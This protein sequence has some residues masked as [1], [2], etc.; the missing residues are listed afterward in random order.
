[1]PGHIDFLWGSRLFDPYELL[2]EPARP[3]PA[4]SSGR[5]LQPTFYFLDWKGG[6]FNLRALGDAGQSLLLEVYALDG[7]LVGQAGTTD[8]LKQSNTKISRVV[9]GMLATD[10]GAKNLRAGQ[11]LL[12]LSQMKRGDE[13]MVLLPRG[14]IHNGTPGLEDFLKPSQARP[15][16]LGEYESLRGS[17]V[18]A[19]DAKLSN[20]KP[21]ATKNEKP[22]VTKT[23][24]PQETKN[25][26]PQLTKNEKPQAT[27]NDVK[28]D[29]PISIALP[30]VFQAADLLGAATVSGGKLQ[31]VSLA[32]PKDPEAKSLDWFGMSSGDRLTLKFDLP[33][34]LSVNLY[35]SFLRGPQAGSLRI[36]VNGQAIGEPIELVSPSET[37]AKLE[38]GHVDL[39][40][41]TNTITIIA[42]PS[43]KN[44]LT[45]ISLLMLSLEK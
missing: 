44:S 28:V 31:L 33:V 21:L 8:S 14:A 20:Q 43:G 19:Q 24:K 12:A 16:Q 11:Y 5:V 38:V 29:A 13:F 39:R 22:L 26:K 18:S 23:E 42:T 45:R 36:L 15:W 40:S 7:Q 25:E 35:V 9:G 3:R 17:G 34:Q 1:L 32:S 41:G 2:G 4:D 27:K 6:D 30:R 37:T 10:L